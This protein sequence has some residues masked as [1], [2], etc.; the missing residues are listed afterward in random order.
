MKGG[1]IRLLAKQAE[2]MPF[3]VCRLGLRL[4]FGI[5][6]FSASVASASGS[7]KRE[8]GE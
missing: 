5:V 1:D 7:T 2:S 4:S 3:L 6:P 8:A